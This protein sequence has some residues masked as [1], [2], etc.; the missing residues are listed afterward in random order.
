MIKN[1]ASR[2]SFTKN[3]NTMHGR[4]NVKFSKNSFVKDRFRHP[5]GNLYTILRVC[6]VLWW[7]RVQ[8]SANIM[9]TNAQETLVIHDIRVLK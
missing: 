4:Q 9:R 5:L 8:I 1:C 6:V 3:H 7:L 2:W